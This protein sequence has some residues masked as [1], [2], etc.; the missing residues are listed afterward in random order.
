MNLYWRT[1]LD[2]VVQQHFGV[3]CL[4]ALLAQRRMAAERQ[5]K[6]QEQLRAH[7]AR[8]RREGNR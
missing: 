3:P 7:L 1:D 6:Q 2:A 5:H 4:A 8:R